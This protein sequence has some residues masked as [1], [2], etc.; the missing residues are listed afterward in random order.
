MPSEADAG[1]DSVC[2]LLLQFY[3]SNTP[4]I[5]LGYMDGVH[6]PFDQERPGGRRRT[7]WKMA[8]IEQSA[9]SRYKDLCHAPILGL[10][11]AFLRA[12]PRPSARV[13]IVVA[14]Q[15]ERNVVDVGKRRRRSSPF[16][17]KFTC[18][19]LTVYDMNL[20]APAELSLVVLV[21]VQFLLAATNYRRNSYG[22]CLIVSLVFC[23]SG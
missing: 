23:K 7:N 15:V 18:L 22:A 21:Y 2:T 1:K 17:A 19:V 10:R 9:P 16:P 4:I 12:E 14:I 3:F 13:D 6:A 11:A 8:T 20:A 5:K